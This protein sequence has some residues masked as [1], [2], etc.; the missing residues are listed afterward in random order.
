MWLKC[1]ICELWFHCHWVL[2]KETETKLETAI[3]AK[4]VESV[5][6]NVIGKVDS[7]IRNMKED[8]S[9]ALEIEKRKK[10][11]GCT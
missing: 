8:V 1:E 4:L 10:V 3:E 9:K 5:E 2:A 11:Q 6:K 7:Q